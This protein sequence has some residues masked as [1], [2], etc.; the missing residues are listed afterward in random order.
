MTDRVL[1]L[2]LLAVSCA[3]IA[4]STY[5]TYVHYQPEALICTGAGGCE[6]VQDSEYAVLAGIPVAVLGLAAWIAV[7][8]LTIWD[9]DLAR[10]VTAAIALAAL[11]FAAYLVILQLVVIDA[12]CIWCMVNDV[13][14]VPILAVLALLRL[15]SPRL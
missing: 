8:A 4:V 11:A 2:A 5:L 3:G 9:S 12:V 15:R 6:A 13:V 7:L 1:R 14:L 10:T